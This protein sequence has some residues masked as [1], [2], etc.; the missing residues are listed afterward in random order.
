MIGRNGTCARNL[1]ARTRERARVVVMV[2]VGHT[3]RAL[4]LENCGERERSSL[5]S[6]LCTCAD[7]WKPWECTLQQLDPVDVCVR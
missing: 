4:E 2:V 7:A 5:S 3:V 1:G 6:S